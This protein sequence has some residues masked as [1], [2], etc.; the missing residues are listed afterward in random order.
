MNTQKDGETGELVA[1]KMKIVFEHDNNADM[2]WLDQDEFKN[3][4]KSNH[5]ALQMSVYKMDGSDE[6]WQL[7]D[8]LGG[9]DCLE[10]AGDWDTGTFYCLNALPKGYLR[11]LAANAGLK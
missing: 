6:D 11:E 9:I 7:I 8:S 5:I 1:R 3:E 2:S 10:D 4:D